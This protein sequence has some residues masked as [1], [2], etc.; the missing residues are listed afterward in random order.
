MRLIASIKHYF[1][2]SLWPVNCGL[3]PKM[4]SG[5]AH[6]LGLHSTIRRTCVMCILQYQPLALA[7]C[8]LVRALFP[9]ILLHTVYGITGVFKFRYSLAWSR[10]CYFVAR[11]VARLCCPYVPYV[12]WTDGLDDA[13]LDGIRKDPTISTRTL[14]VMV[15]YPSQSSTT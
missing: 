2:V 4:S 7:S 6:T 9:V 14:T 10:C 11:S 15:P 1:T 8:R 12:P 5:Q 3:W 13:A